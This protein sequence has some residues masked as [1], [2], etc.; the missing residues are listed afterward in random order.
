MEGSVPDKRKNGKELKP[1]LGKKEYEGELRNLQTKL[2]EMQEWVT[3]SR[4]KVVVVFEGRDAAGKGGVIHRI[5]ERVSPRVVRHVA[6]PAPTERER[7]QLYMQRYLK[8]MPAG[9]EMAAPL[10]SSKCQREIP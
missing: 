3:A 8:E 7:S 5:M 2:V 6:L 4:A 10:V 9:G 1:E